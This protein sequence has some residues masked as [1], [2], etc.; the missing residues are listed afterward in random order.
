MNAIKPQ[1]LP[2][3]YLSIV[4]EGRPG[5]IIN[6][7][8]PWDETLRRDEHFYSLLERRTVFKKMSDVL[9]LCAQNHTV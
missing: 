6:L 2:D 7:D 4:Q 5:Y 8:C 1:M 3:Y 9:I